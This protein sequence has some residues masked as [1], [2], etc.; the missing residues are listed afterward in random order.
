MEIAYE[1]VDDS[2]AMHRVAHEFERTIVSSVVLTECIDNC[3]Q[4]TRRILVQNLFRCYFGPSPLVD[5]VVE[6]KKELLE[7]SLGFD[8]V[9]LGLF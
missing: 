9:E 3:T 6:F 2:L 5:P 8:I 7:V 1:L 4:V